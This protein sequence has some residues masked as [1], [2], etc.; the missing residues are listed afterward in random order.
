M[1]LAKTSLVNYFPLEG[2]VEEERVRQEAT[3]KFW[4]GGSAVMLRAETTLSTLGWKGLQPF[5]LESHIKSRLAEFHATPPQSI[6]EGSVKNAER[7]PNGD[8]SLCCAPG[9]IIM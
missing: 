1:L 3:R 4:I 8:D 6:L 9:K 5:L 7:I 2:P